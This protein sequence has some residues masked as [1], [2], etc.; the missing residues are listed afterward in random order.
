MFVKVTKSKN[1]HYLQIVESYREGGKCK[2]RV[3]A[4]LGRFEDFKNNTQLISLGKRFLQLAG[5]EIQQNNFKDINE[6]E[7]IN[8]GY[9][10]YKKLIKQLKI[11]QILEKIIETKKVKYNFS[12]SILLMIL[13]RL[14]SPSSKLSSYENQCRYCQLGDI[15]LNHLYRSLD[16]LSENKEYIET[17]LFKQKRTL[18]NDRV[19]IIF[20]D[21]TTFYFESV[22]S[23]SL[24]KF[25]FSKDGKFK[26]VQVV[27]GLLTDSNGFPVGYELF[28]GNTFEGKTLELSLSKL[29][30]RFK[31]NDVIIVADRAMGSKDNLLSIINKSYSYIIGMKAKAQKKTLKDQII[32]L[33]SYKFDKSLGIKYKVL[34]N[35]TRTFK[36]SKKKHT[37]KENLL[38]IWSEKRAEKDKK[39][40]IRLIE[41]A[42]KILSH[43]E[44]IT[45]K[46]GARKYIKT[47][48][49]QSSVEGLDLER[50]K[51][52]SE[53]DGFYVIETN[54]SDLSHKKILDAYHSLWRIEES[55]RIMKTTMET[56]PIFH[57][58]EHRIKGHFVLC[59]IAFLLQRSLEMK[60]K[61]NEIDVSPEKIKKAINS[62]EMSI[63][64]IDKKKYY[65]KG[66]SKPLGNKILNIMRIK[67]IKNL[68]PLEGFELPI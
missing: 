56:R 66:K 32:N 48:N 25:G 22:R 8:Y 3:L 61:N 10:V 68:N 57:W 16:I 36:A 19:D 7:R 30:Q 46:R 31:I 5:H 63:L 1:F 2:H 52:D 11:D 35:Y 12:L 44:L 6:L 24:R 13:D 50:I 62:L 29:S 65:L 39:D 38:C 41:K 4:N 21:V 49:I 34:K 59:F 37:L 17:E 58:T 40:R 45:N 33:S 43:K 55:F 27:L 64:E 67:H 47:S 15:G 20:Y 53:W 60:L 14:L 9:I 26:E 23:D 54:R 28:P 18:F 42:E 51:E